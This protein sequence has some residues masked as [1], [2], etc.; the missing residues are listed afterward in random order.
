M[1]SVGIFVG[2]ASRRMGGRPK[3]LLTTPDGSTTLVERLLEQSKLALGDVPC[4]LVGEHAGYAHLRLPMLPDARSEQ[5]PLGGLV[6]L[7]AHGEAHGVDAVLCLACDMPYV[8]SGLIAR[9]AREA[10]EA[11]ACAPRPEGLWQP[12]C[13]RYQVSAALPVA[14]AALEAGRLS[15]QKI[16]STLGAHELALSADEALSLRDWDSPDDLRR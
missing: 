11:A 7:L 2:G 4:V 8:T 3:G 10:P 13:A 12:L 6:A 5:G 16:L 9:V 15:L 1:Q 14:R